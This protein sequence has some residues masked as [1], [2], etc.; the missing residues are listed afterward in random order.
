MHRE[1]PD[2]VQGMPNKHCDQ[3]GLRGQKDSN[4]YKEVVPDSKMLTGEHLLN[5]SLEI[6]LC[7]HTRK[8]YRVCTRSVRILHQ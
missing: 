8:T 3:R 7:S 5:F 1:D 4:R 2:G 6:D